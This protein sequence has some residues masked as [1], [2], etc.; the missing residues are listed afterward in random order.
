MTTA[1]LITRISILDTTQHNTTLL[2]GRTDSSRYVPP[3]HVVSNTIVVV[4][5]VHVVQNYC[6]ARHLRRTEVILPLFISHIKI[7]K[8][9][10]KT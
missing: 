1:N 9:E 5:V 2:L 4:V 10:T 7:P 8:R 6:P 3:R